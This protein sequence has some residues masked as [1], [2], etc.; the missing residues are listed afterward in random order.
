LLQ[1]LKNE[2]PHAGVPPQRLQQRIAFERLLARLPRDGEWVLKGGFGLHFRYGFET[3][4]TKDVDLRTNL[5]PAAA[6]ERLR[7][8]VATATSPPDN[9]SF[10]LGEVV[11]ELQ[12]APGGSL[13]VPVVARVAGRE[14][15]RF[16]LDLSSG[17]ALVDEPETLKGSGLLEFAGIPAIEFPVYPVTQQLAEKLH[18]YT[19]LRAQENTRV[20]DLADIAIFAANERVD[21]HRLDESV[22]ATFAARA[23]HPVPDH[24]PEPPDSWAQPYASLAREMRLLPTDSLSG[25]FALAAEFWNPFLSQA[26]SSGVWHPSER[27]WIKGVD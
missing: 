21:A 11:E 2:A 26:G 19:L 10:E 12:G 24:L 17:D 9:F 1:R 6:L 5:S 7:M 23:T 8:A 20:K 14:L 13:S 15:S 4:S 25:A 16:H 22:Q 3:R 27:G 18:A